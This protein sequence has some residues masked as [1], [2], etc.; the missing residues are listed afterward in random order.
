[1]TIASIN[2]NGTSFVQT[3][4]LGASIT[5]FTSSLGW[6]SDTGQLTVKLV[7]DKCAGPKLEY[8]L[9]G[10]ASTSNAPDS[11]SPPPLGSPVWF[12]YGLFTF[13]GILQN[14]REVNSSSSGKTYEVVINDPRDVLEAAHLI[15][16]GYNGP[17]FGIPNMFNVYGYMEAFE[18]LLGGA[19][20]VD[21]TLINL[22]G[23]ISNIG[24]GGAQVNEDGMPW[25]LIKRALNNM[26]NSGFGVNTTYGGPRIFFKGYSYSV[27]LTEVPFTPEWYRIPAENMT[28]MDIVGKVC[29]ETGFD[30]YCQLTP[31][32]SGNII[33]VKTV[34]RIAQ[35]S[36]AYAVDQSTGAAETRLNFGAIS[37]TIGDGTGVEGNS[38]GIELRNE[39]ANTMLVGDNR[40]ELWMM[41]YSGFGN[42]VSDTIWPFWGLRHDGSPV[43]ATGFDT[44]HCFW[45]FAGHWGVGLT[46]YPICLN[47]IR[48][49]MGGEEVWRSWLGSCQPAKARALGI[50]DSILGY[51]D[52]A[53]SH[54]N[55]NLANN[56]G[57]PADATDT[58]QL[59]A[60]HASHMN[61]FCNSTENP[62]D[63][64]SRIHSHITQLASMYGR[65]FMVQLPFLCKATEFSSGEIRFNWSLADGAW[66]EGNVLGLTQNS[67][68]LDF[69]RD[70]DGKIGAFVAFPGASLFDASDVPTDDWYIQGNTLYVRCTL[71][72]IVFLDPV[73]KL[74]P[75]AVIELAGPVWVKN[76]VVNVLPQ[77]MAG[78]ELILDCAGATT[79]QKLNVQRTL[80]GVGGNQVYYEAGR[81]AVM[82]RGAAVPLRSNNLSYG[83]WMASTGNTTVYGPQG[84]ADYERDAAFSPWNFGGLT[85][86]GIAALLHVNGKLTYTQVVEQGNITAVGAPAYK[87]GDI[88]SAS[89]PNLTNVDCTVST[90]GVRTNYRFRT[91]TPKFGIFSKERIDGIRKMGRM[92]S[93][94]R[95]TYNLT[96]LRRRNEVFSQMQGLMLRRSVLK[97]IRA[98]SNTPHLLLAAQAKQEFGSESVRQEVVT[99]ELRQE[100]GN[101]YNWYG[102][103]AA[104]SLN[105]V[106]RPFSTNR[107]G[108]ETKIASFGNPSF[109]GWFSKDQI[110]PVNNE[111]N[112]AVNM[113]TLNP[114]QN[115]GGIFG[116]GTTSAGHDIEYVV[117][118]GSYPA[119]LSVRNPSDN[120]GQEYRAIGLRGPL[121]LV[122]WG[123]DTNNKPVPNATPETPS[124]RFA[125]NFLRRPDL[126]KAGPVDLRWD[127]D[128]GVWTAPTSMK[129]SVANVCLDILPGGTGNAILYNDEVQDG[130]DGSPAFSSCGRSFT[131]NVITI[132]NSTLT[133]L[134]AGG[135][136]WVYYDTRHLE[137]RAIAPI[138]E[139][140]MGKTTEDHDKAA[141]GL[142][143][144]YGGGG[145]SEYP[146]GYTVLAYNRFADLKVN[147]WC[148]VEWMNVG[149]EIYAGE[150]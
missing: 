1:M 124:I 74:G 106:F 9:F 107:F 40:H 96:Y 125:D 32:P 7:Q 135:D 11:F 110:G 38:R 15:L 116:Y 142:I 45:A 20:N 129:I 121:V 48:A 61:F 117:R 148:F 145:G 92:Q 126:W 143:A 147:K 136:Y 82:P 46:Y 26:I 31:T 2:C 70:D 22:M 36:P 103:S 39:V 51:A 62:Q 10:N 37:K 18:Q 109:F 60:S 133:Y 83:P 77:H 88:L 111:F 78:N 52:P 90:D 57:L 54:A 13:G 84:K 50:T 24:F 119:S 138:T 85:N 16:G 100:I 99:S 23:Y 127:E 49:A 29:E 102:E 68:G 141:Y 72:E 114:F 34:A 113:W 149:F 56:T 33:K 30:F 6:N 25:N 123:F 118:D 63:Y 137:W 8:D 86:M 115:S 28:L 4:F 58:S 75:R 112:L 130:P 132:Q 67:P 87:L 5:D 140:L 101:L 41:P 69:F 53:Q 139:R 42:G 21:S 120:Y 94:L 104:V 80:A 79:T 81:V 122:G 43:I 44:D 65:K 64:V 55:S 66:F 105:G 59:V 108:S 47:E 35:P 91:Y 73:R 3:R 131:Q 95:R 76:C 98:K 27:D 144:V 146:L 134:R 89:G 19:C 150:C 17:T 128:R 14:W 97:N 93:K 71:E 12:Q